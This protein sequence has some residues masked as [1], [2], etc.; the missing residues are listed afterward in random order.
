MFKVSTKGDYGLL[1]LSGIAEKMNSGRKFVS[2][3]EIADEKKL[4]LRYLSQIILPLKKAG[5]VKSR[6]GRIGGY[7]LVKQPSKIRIIEILELLEGRLA[8]VRC[9]EKR[10]EKCGS[11]GK[12]NLK[13]M[14]MQ[15]KFML[16]Q[17][18]SKKTLEDLLN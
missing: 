7:M 15:A 2:L 1:L 12:C 11:A 8:P 4:S 10:T 3:K 6:E 18:L 17:F 16:F 14:W 13:G 5:F 9:C